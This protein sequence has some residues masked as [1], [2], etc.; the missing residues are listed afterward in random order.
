MQK[1]K[2]GP[3]AARRA[4]HRRMHVVLSGRRA[5]RATM[6]ALLA[7]PR[8]GARAPVPLRPPHQH[9]AESLPSH[10][11]FLPLLCAAASTLRHEPAT[12]HACAALSS[13]PEST[14]PTPRPRNPPAE[15]HATPARPR[16]R[17]LHRPVEDGRA[18]D[19]GDGAGRDPLP[20]DDR[21]GHLHAL[22]LRLHL[23]VEDL[24]IVLRWRGEMQA[25]AR[26]GAGGRPARPGAAKVKGSL[27]KAP[28]QARRELRTRRT[29]RRRTPR[30]QAGMQTPSQPASRARAHP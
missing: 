2:C 27:R 5:E 28:G 14:G 20:V 22:H 29:Q 17:T 9:H 12:I 21:L 23:E 15:P 25:G 4:R 3:E 7:A 10:P 30:R 1:C 24:Q 11:A 13:P 6:Q 8:V 19:E 16:L 18:R 26:R